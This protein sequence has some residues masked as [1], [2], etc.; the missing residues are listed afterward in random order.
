MKLVSK[1][2]GA[3]LSL[4]VALT[5]VIPAALAMQLAAVSVADAAVVSRIEVRGNQRVDPGTVKGNI[6]IKPGKSFSKTDIDESVKRLFATGLFSDVKIDQAG[7]ALVVTVSEY[8]LVNQVLFQGNKKIKDNELAANVQIKPRTPFNPDLV[9][10]SIDVI[11]AAYQRIGRNDVTVTEKSM[12]VG[13]GRVNVVFEINE[14]SRTKIANINFVGNHAFP[15]RRLRDLLSTKQSNFLSW[16]TRNDVYSDPRMQADE[17]RLRQFYYNHGYADFR[18]VS[19][20]ANLDPAKNAYTV[21]I[22]VDEGARYHFGA[23]GIQSSVKGIDGESLRGLVTTREGNL[24]DASKVQDTLVALSENVAGKGYAFAKVEPHGNRN[25]QNHTIAIDY[26]IDEGPRVYIQ[27][28]EVRGNDRTRD[29]VIRRELDFNE[30][31][32]FNQVLVERGKKR[33]E[34]LDYFDSVQITTEPGSDP[35]QVVLVVTVVEKATGDFSIGA[36]YTTGGAD[37]GF[38]LQGSITE[39]NFLG[40]G[41]YV[42]VSAGGGQHS[43]AYALSF[44]EPYFLGQ[45]IAA[46]FDIYKTRNTLRGTHSGAQYDVDT[47]G[48]TVRFGLPITQALT[49]NVAYNISQTR[50]DVAD[51]PAKSC[52]TLDLSKYICDAEDNSPW[53]KSS[54]SYGLVFNTI[55]DMKN[56][57]DGIYANFSQEVAGLG[58]DAKFLATTFRGRYY[59]TLSEQADIV[60]LVAVGAGYIHEF[61]GDGV[62][63]FDLYK[64]GPDY[65]R[66]F[67]YN[68]Y[69]PYDST[70]KDFLGGTTYLNATAEMQFPLPAVP[71]SFGLRGAVFA[72]AGTLFG[73]PSQFTGVDGTS[74]AWRASVGASIIWAS[75]FGPL[76]FDYGVPVVKQAND[77]IQN[78]NFG[79][80]TKF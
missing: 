27:R 64:G 15:G 20:D 62:Q 57:H 3:A 24:Y 71:E 44:T 63:I 19:T 36:G 75:P 39:R 47:V 52:A 13:S 54:V 58:G 42:K 34:D 53:L 61:G 40:R 30:G 59:K 31:D 65:I 70:S 22:T 6:T 46:G 16:L 68:G 38:Q 55:D 77:Q 66:G 35:D 56:P 74:L 48:G 23:I 8:Q 7:S 69:G 1:L 45:R 51:Y 28:I 60:G 10:P 32:P 79:I 14:G 41:H 25:F 26:T 2:Y 43:R 73:L 11:K 76:R 12:D 37:Q 67:R 29:Y 50:Y 33:L 9:Q 72:D 21:T 5:L 17:Q 78:F 4:A 80:S 49:A 18:I